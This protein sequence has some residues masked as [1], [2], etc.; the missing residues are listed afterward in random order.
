MRQSGD[1]KLTCTRIAA[2]NWMLGRLNFFDFF[3]YL[4]QVCTAR[5]TPIST[6][7]QLRRNTQAPLRTACAST[8]LTQHLI[9]YNKIIS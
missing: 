1:W 3:F 8:K 6:G 4:T 9:K 7:R 2:N 5:A